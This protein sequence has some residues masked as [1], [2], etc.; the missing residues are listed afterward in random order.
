MV[1]PSILLI[2]PTTVGRT[3]TIAVTVYVPSLAF[4]WRNRMESPTARSPRRMIAPPFVM[5]VESV[6]AIVRVQPSSVLSDRDEP[7]MA[8]MVMSRKPTPTPGNPPRKPNIGPPFWPARPGALP[9]GFA[10][11]G[12]ALAAGAGAPA[13]ADGSAPAADVGSLEGPGDAPIAAATPTRTRRADPVIT[14][15]RVA[16][17]RPVPERTR[18]WKATP[19]SGSVIAPTSCDVGAGAGFTGVRGAGTGTGWVSLLSFDSVILDLRGTG[20]SVDEVGRGANMRVEPS[21]SLRAGQYANRSA[22]TWSLPS[23]SVRTA[24]STRCIIDTG[25]HR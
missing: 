23:P 8:V 2:S 11:F 9:F 22:W 5:V 24:P 17:E 12:S 19:G 15:T 1:S 20:L 7:S 4:S 16:V 25:P 6:T 21:R 10:A 18:S 3:T 14:P 13:D